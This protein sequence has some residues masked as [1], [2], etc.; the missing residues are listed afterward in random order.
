[1]SSL[2]SWH[3][4]LCLQLKLYLNVVRIASYYRDNIIRSMM[5][6]ING[7]GNTIWEMRYTITTVIAIIIVNV[8]Y[9]K[10]SPSLILSSQLLK[11]LFFILTS[12]LFT[13]SFPFSY[14]FYIQKVSSWCVSCTCEM[15]WYYHYHPPPHNK[16]ETF[17]TTA[18]PSSLPLL[19]SNATTRQD[20][21]T[22]SIPP[23][24]GNL[25][26]ELTSYFCE[27]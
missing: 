20:T 12:A 14:I 2:S 25:N 1:M 26:N 15:W 4:I 5:I 23:E 3:Y 6:L 7:K 8:L 9:L 27:R 13:C 19:F 24:K 21:T 18:T 22:N 10:C 11:N 17:S 16:V